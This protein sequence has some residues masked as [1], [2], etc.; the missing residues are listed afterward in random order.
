MNHLANLKTG[1]YN[2]TCAD[3]YS[4]KGKDTEVIDGILVRKP[5]CI[6]DGAGVG[7]F[8]PFVALVEMLY[9]ATNTNSTQGNSTY[10]N[11]TSGNS[12]YANSTQGNFTNANYTETTTA[13]SVSKPP[14]KDIVI[15]FVHK[16]DSIEETEDIKPEDLRPEMQNSYSVMVPF[17]V[18]V[19][20][21]FALLM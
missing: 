19:F 8:S 2:C 9:N 14:V 13:E 12:T 10:A 20:S 5:G 18:V 15:H 11:S 16:E 17:C 3:G 7:V 4:G 21:F 1:S 6:K